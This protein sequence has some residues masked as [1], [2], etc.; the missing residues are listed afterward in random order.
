MNS[1]FEF[2]CVMEKQTFH[3]S[4]SGTYQED[5]EENK[6]YIHNHLSSSRHYQQPVCHHVWRSCAASSQ[7]KKK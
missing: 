6:Q 3:N 7:C 2:V 1:I 5:Y 4:G